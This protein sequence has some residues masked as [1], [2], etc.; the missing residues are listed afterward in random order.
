[1]TLSSYFPAG[2]KRGDTLLYSLGD[3]GALLS[4]QV[5]AA[6]DWHISLK[7]EAFAFSVMTSREVASTNAP[8][9]V[10][11]NEEV[12]TS[13]DAQAD[14]TSKP[15]HLRVKGGFAQGGDVI[16]I[17]ETDYEAYQTEEGATSSVLRLGEGFGD[18]SEMELQLQIEE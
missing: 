15:G 2:M 3:S 13:T 16:A 1:M 18:Y 11:V 12:L 10:R 5:V 14:T 9:R 7:S 8:S 4:L 6:E 17:I